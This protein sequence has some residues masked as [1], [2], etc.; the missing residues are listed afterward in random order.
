MKEIIIN[1]NEYE[2][3]YF[4]TIQALIKSKKIKLPKRSKQKI[5][6]N[7][8]DKNE[9]CLNKEMKIYKECGPFKFYSNLNEKFLNPIDNLSTKMPKL[10]QKITKLHSKRE[11]MDSFYQTARLFNTHLIIRN[12]F[13]ILLRKSLKKRKWKNIII[14]FIVLPLII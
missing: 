2:H 1:S 3:P 8:L 12:V 11:K 5:K 13:I 10:I 6:S 9:E 7:L 14:I 4:K